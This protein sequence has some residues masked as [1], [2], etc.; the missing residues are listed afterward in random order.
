MTVKLIA[1]TRIPLVFT[2]SAENDDMMDVRDTIEHELQWTEEENESDPERI[3]EFAGRT[4]Y[5][6]YTRPNEKT[7]KIEDYLA[8]IIEQGHESVFEHAHFVFYVDGVSRNLLLELE[9]HRHLSFSVISQRFVNSE[10]TPLVIP[11][12]LRDVAGHGF[13][14]SVRQAQ[15]AYSGT[16]AY[17]MSQ[18]L[19]RKAAREAARAILPGGVETKFVV[20]GNARAWRDVLRKRFSA[21][22]DA[23]ICEF[24]GEVLGL[25]REN[26]PLLFQDFPKEPF[27]V[28]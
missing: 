4:C 14:E 21:H 19:G 9:R 28:V 27:N 22:A 6:S 25:L 8:N 10:N 26:S 5:Q 20:S 18:G 15:D 23:E 13:E 3:V 24:A 12:A 17:L 1:Y 2:P 16:V 7:R 11:P